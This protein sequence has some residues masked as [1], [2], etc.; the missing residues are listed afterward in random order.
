MNSLTYI[1]KEV[2]HN[3]NASHDPN[4][5]CNDPQQNRRTIMAACGFGSQEIFDFS[6]TA[7]SAIVKKVASASCVQGYDQ[8]LSFCG[9]GWVDEGEECDYCGSACDPYCN[10]DCTLKPGIQCAPGSGPC[11][12]SEGVFLTAG[13]QCGPS[14]H[15]IWPAPTCTGN[16]FTCPSCWPSTENHWCTRFPGVSPCVRNNL[17]CKTACKIS[18]T[19]SCSSNFEGI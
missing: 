16:N 11:C 3:H 1:Y 15:N 7:V 10:P 6:S 14:R 8:P 9:N 19:S 12:S 17:Y 2:G 4:T 5:G 13:T 18:P